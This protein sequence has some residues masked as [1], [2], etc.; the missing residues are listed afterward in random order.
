MKLYIKSIL[1]LFFVVFSSCEDKIDVQVPLGTTRL[2]IEASLGWAKGT[3][4]N[5][6]SIK[7][8]TS[9][10]YFDTSKNNKAIGASVKVTNDNS[11]AEYFFV[12]QKDGTYAIS[13][14]V[15][16]IN[17]SYTLEVVYNNETYVAHETLM[18][19]VKINNIKQSR[20]EGLDKQLL[21]VTVSWSDPVDEENYYLVK[22]ERED[23]VLPMLSSF[24]DE[25]NNGNDIE[26]FFEKGGE[27]DEGPFLVDDVVDIYLYGVSKQY[28]NYIQLLIKQYYIADGNLFGTIPSEIKGNCIN[29]D[30]TDNYAF[31]YFRLSEYDTVNYTF[32]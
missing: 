22:L 19:V 29:L 7:L 18:P 24:S 4:G 20:E 26:E 25:F 13:N 15:P 1:V 3:E 30:N 5:N 9:T 8:S 21:E 31:G 23:T 27:G 10:A 32:K 12:D 14:F 2:V 6:Q 28:L 16:I 11:G 17:D